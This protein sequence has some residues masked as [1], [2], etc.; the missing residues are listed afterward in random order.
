MNTNISRLIPADERVQ[1]IIQYSMFCDLRPFFTYIQAVLR[2][3]CM[4][5][6]AKTSSLACTKIGPIASQKSVKQIEN[7]AVYWQFLHGIHST[8]FCS[9]DFCYHVNILRRMK[10]MPYKIELI[11]ER[12]KKL[13]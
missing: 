13:N 11:N 4:K 7:G 2:N 10:L 3:L 9:D 5:L 8:W 12:K 1:S 6:D